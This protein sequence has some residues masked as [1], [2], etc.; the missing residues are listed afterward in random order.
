[1]LPGVWLLVTVWVLGGVVRA[2]F[3]S[4]A[5]ELLYAYWVY[6]LDVEVSSAQYIADE[7]AKP[8][9][10]PKAPP[11]DPNEARPWMVANKAQGGWNEPGDW[12]SGIIDT[13]KPG[14]NFHGF[15]KGTAQPGLGIQ[16]GRLEGQ[17]R[18]ADPWAPKLNEIQDIMRFPFDDGR[19][20]DDINND[21]GD[22]RYSYKGFD[23]DSLYGGLGET[24]KDG[25]PGRYFK[26]DN[27]LT[28]LAKRA[29]DLYAKN[30]ALARDYF[31]L[32]RE[33]LRDGRLARRMEEGSFKI[34]A[35]W[36]FCH[37]FDLKENKQRPKLIEADIKTKSPK[38]LVGAFKGMS[39]KD[40][41]V[42]ST[43]D[44]LKKISDKT[45]R[46]KLIKALEEEC[47]DWDTKYNWNSNGEI[48]G[49]IIVREEELEKALKMQLNEKGPAPPT[50]LGCG[51]P[52]AKG[53]GETR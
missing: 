20:L 24:A 7:L 12:S 52:A 32:M 29:S 46:E 38:I 14:L 42:S 43:L 33:A 36:K 21:R 31:R 48:H 6:R 17:R 9:R 49:R 34:A 2:G 44:G 4:R 19:P 51:Y 15:V 1:M 8:G 25:P 37:A 53:W 28:I 27:A 23:L 45:F 50:A 5:A 18:V 10:D 30:P 47:K 40:F 35:A 22:Y 39:Y 13:S 26:F 16:Y 41:D 11:P 3:K